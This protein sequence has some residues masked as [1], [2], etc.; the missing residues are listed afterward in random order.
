MPIWRKASGGSIRFFQNKGNVG[1]LH[2]D[3]TMMPY[4]NCGTIPVFRIDVVEMCVFVSAISDYLPVSAKQKSYNLEISRHS[5]A[6]FAVCTYSMHSHVAL[7]H[8]TVSSWI[9]IRRQGTRS[10]KA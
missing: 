9:M 6:V 8:S 1:T 5:D 7:M 4:S 2:I 3:S 10:E